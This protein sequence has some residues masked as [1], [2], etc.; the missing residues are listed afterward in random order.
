MFFIVF[1]IFLCI[2]LFFRNFC[3]LGI[4]FLFFFYFPNGLW[5]LFKYI[6][7]NNMYWFGKQ[8]G[9]QI[10]DWYTIHPISCH[11]MCY[12]IWEFTFR[13]RTIVKCVV[14]RVSS[15]QFFKIWY[16]MMR[17]TWGSKVIKGRRKIFNGSKIIAKKP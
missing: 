12:Y 1:N 3:K 10:H 9:I 17:K 2:P 11:F 6:K 7:Y 14:A 13:A 4:C 15:V 5:L 8:S 16:Q